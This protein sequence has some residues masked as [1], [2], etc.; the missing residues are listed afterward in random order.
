MRSKP[1]VRSWDNVGRRDEIEANRYV[2]VKREL[3]CRIFGRLPQC[4]GYG[5]DEIEANR[6]VEVTRKLD[7]RIFGRL[8]QCAG[9]GSW[10]NV[11]RRDEI[12]ASRQDY[13][14]SFPALP[15]CAQFGRN[16]W[17]L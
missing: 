16:E 1:T 5:R 12:E 4:A 17:A 15:Q 2:E 11:G 14:R 7:C 8:P 9:Y 6:Y 10:D 13:C 3:D